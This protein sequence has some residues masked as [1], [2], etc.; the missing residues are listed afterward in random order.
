VTYIDVA[1]HRYD[2]ALAMAALAILARLETK[3]AFDRVIYCSEIACTLK[4]ASGSEI[5]KTVERIMNLVR[6]PH[7]IPPKLVSEASTM[8]VDDTLKDEQ[9]LIMLATMAHERRTTFSRMV[10]RYSEYK[11]PYYTEADLHGTKRIQTSV[12]HTHRTESHLHPYA[13]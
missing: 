1:F 8:L 2:A 6:T 12:A 5:T 4:E 13:D 3:P 7:L 9:A 11:R 10:A